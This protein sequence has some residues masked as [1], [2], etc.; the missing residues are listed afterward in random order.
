[1]PFNVNRNRYLTRYRITVEDTG[2]NSVQVPYEDDPQLNFAYF[3][4]GGRLTG[5]G[6]S[7]RETPR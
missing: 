6:R 3:V 2:G 1:M 5:G 7:A 4:Y